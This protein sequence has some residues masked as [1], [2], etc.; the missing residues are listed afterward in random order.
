MKDKVD[1]K[2]YF[3]EISKQ[4]LEQHLSALADISS[5][6]IRRL[7]K[8]V[9]E[10]FIRSYELLDEKSISHVTVQCKIILKGIRLHH[11]DTGVWLIL[12]PRITLKK[13]YGYLRN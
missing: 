1:L 4:G 9:P 11:I 2:K 13:A 12:T 6:A 5:I 8:F 3:E 7:K 10:G